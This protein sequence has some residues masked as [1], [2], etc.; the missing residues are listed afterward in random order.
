[1]RAVIVVGGD[2]K[3]CMKQM[4]RGFI[5]SWAE[6]LTTGNRMI[7][8]S[9]ETLAEEPRRSALKSRCFRMRVRLLPDVLLKTGE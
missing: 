7:N 9:V 2:G 1:M 5:R 6:D 4:K 8:A 3:R